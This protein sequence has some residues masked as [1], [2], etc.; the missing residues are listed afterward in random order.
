[1]LCRSR[2]IFNQ[3]HVFLDTNKDINILVLLPDSHILKIFRGFFAVLLEQ[4]HY[5][6]I[7]KNALCCQDFGTFA[8]FNDFHCFRIVY[9]GT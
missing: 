7:G 1:M 4:G 2:F 5:I 8:F 6:P 9:A 3:Q